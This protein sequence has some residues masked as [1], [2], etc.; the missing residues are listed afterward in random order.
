MDADEKRL[1]LEEWAAKKQW[2][3]PYIHR[4]AEGMRGVLNADA[5]GALSEGDAEALRAAKD[6]F[7]SIVCEIGSG[8]GRHLIARA[9][10]DP[11][12]LHVGIEARF[13]R[14]YR[15]AEKA[16]QHGLKNLLVIR[17]R[18][19]HLRQY[20]KEQELRGIY[21]LFPD[22]WEKRRWQRHRLLSQHNMIEFSRCI[23]PAGFF[24]YRTDHCEY[25]EA[26]VEMVHQTGLPFVRVNDELASTDT[27][28]A[29]E[30]EL[31]FRSQN[32]DV[33]TAQWSI[34]GTAG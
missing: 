7:S 19:E 5:F 20:F 25:F 4:I 18:A 3:N 26:T 15:T 14:A 1:S 21:C 32:K 12:T 33:F 22:P 30:F 10:Q 11:N 31:L 16:A 9:L 24:F 6:R 17:G 29:S 2:V 8:S 28:T 23:Q 34:E 13:K 27:A